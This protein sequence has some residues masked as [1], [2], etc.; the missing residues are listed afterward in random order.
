MVD[1][2]ADPIRFS[3]VVGGTVTTAVERY[4]GVRIFGEMVGIL[5]VAG[6]HAAALRLEEMWNDLGRA[7]RFSLLC[8]YPMEQMQ[9]EASGALLTGVCATH[10]RVIPTES[11]S[12]LATEDDRLRAIAVLQQKAHSLAAEIAERQRTEQALQSLLRVS[13]KLHACLDL[14]TLLDHL[15]AESL[16]LVGAEAG[17]LAPYVGRHGLSEVFLPVR[18][19]SAG[20]LLADRGTA[21]QAGCSNIRCRI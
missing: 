7:Y 2:M 4:G 18:S 19:R 12:V 16:R 10:G 11:Y 9:G 5:A 15:V 6:H 3:A 8:G 14:E 1:G 21:Y 17:W 13:E 20:L